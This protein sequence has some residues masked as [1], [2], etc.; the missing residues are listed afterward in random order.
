VQVAVAHGRT[1]HA[2]AERGKHEGQ[3]TDFVALARAA[4]DLPGPATHDSL[5]SAWFALPAWHCI[6]APSPAGWMP[7]AQPINGERCV[8]AFTDPNRAD[9]YARLAALPVDPRVPSPVLSLHAEAMLQIVPQ[10]RAWGVS[11]LAVD[12][13]PDAFYTRLDALFG[14]FQRYRVARVPAQPPAAPPP[15]AQRMSPPVAPPV[16][17]PVSTIA[18]LLALP[19]WHLVTTREDPAFPDLA[20]RGTELVAQIY[21]SAQ[22]VLR[23]AGSPPPPIAVMQ[24]RDALALLADIELVTYVRFDRQLELSFFDLKL[25]SHAG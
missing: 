20:A 15:P 5:W 1:G 17:P 19:A 14:M 16:S 6:K 3:V 13:G 2:V 10:L 21:S 22:A 24:P 23:L 9:G 8:L 7:F 11:A 12:L 4:R 25:G 18:S